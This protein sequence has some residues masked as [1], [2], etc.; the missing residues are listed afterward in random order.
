MNLFI[1][2]GAV[3][4]VLASYL[5]RSGEAVVFSVRPGREAHYGAPK[6]LVMSGNQNLSH[7][8]PTV[9]STPDYTQATRI[10]IGCKHQHLPAII[11]Q[12]RSHL[13]NGVPL[14]PCLN[15]V[16]HIE[17]LQREFPNNPVCPITVMFNAQLP[18]PMAPVLT[19]SPLVFIDGDA[20]LLLKALKSAGMIANQGSIA[21]AWGKLILN[22]NN[23]IGA[24]TQS[25]FKDLLISPPHRQAALAAF[26]EATSVLNG[27]NIDFD[28]PTPVSWRMQRLILRYLPKFAWQIAKKRNQLSDQSY[29]SMLADINNRNATEVAQLNGEIVRQAKKIGMNAPINKKLEELVGQQHGKPARFITIEQLNEHLGLR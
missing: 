12:L 3:T 18:A 10:F 19:T 13:P 27:A 22:L 16:S 2:A 7:T 17:L 6:S 14:L 25:T 28:V 1:G 26:D 15:G 24:L 9:T 29:P 5:L 4:T 20:P 23:A 11:K 21:T 8:A